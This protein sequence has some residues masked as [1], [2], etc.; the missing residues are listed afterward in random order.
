MADMDCDQCK[1]HEAEMIRRE[2]MRKDLDA[3]HD[4]YTVIKKEL[5]DIKLAQALT[6]NDIKLIK[7]PFITAFAAGMVYIIQSI[8]ILLPVSV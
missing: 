4:C 7:W 5:N 3:L 6:M 1:F 8:L 2:N